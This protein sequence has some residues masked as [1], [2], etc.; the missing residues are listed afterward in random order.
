[1]VDNLCGYGKDE[2]AS[3]TYQIETLLARYFEIDL[4]KADK[5]REALLDYT[6][7]MQEYREKGGEE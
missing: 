6:R 4:K 2:L 7:A 5:E 3:M 1:M